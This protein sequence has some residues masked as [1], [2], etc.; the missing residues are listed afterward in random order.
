[1]GLTPKN[2]NLSRRGLTLV[3]TMF[4]VVAFGMLVGSFIAIQMFGLRHSQLV[5]SKLGASDQSR[6][7]LQK[8][9]WEI[10]GAKAW[11][12]GNVSGSN[13]NTYAEVASS[14]AL[15]GTS[16]RLYPYGANTNTYI[17]YHFNTNSQKLYR[18]E[19]GVSGFTLVASDLTN[20]MFFQ[21]EDY[22]GNVINNST[23]SRIWRN[24]VRVVLEFA[25]FQ[26]PMTAIGSNQL[27][28]YYKLEYKIAPHCPSLP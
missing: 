26:Y 12:V 22:R 7:L 16:I 4:T 9:G 3:E 6:Y 25:K 1:M 23:D 17:Q 13:L 14:A 10:R 21:V 19:S 8:M 24:C 28:D 2:S 20:N 15:K 27:Y 5:E 11:D 18:S